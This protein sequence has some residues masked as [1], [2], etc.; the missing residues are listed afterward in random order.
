ML[1]SAWTAS[2]PE[3]LW[4]FSGV[5]HKMQVVKKPETAQTEPCKRIMIGG[6]GGI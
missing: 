3:K 4:G 6:T 1:L 2:E 5:W